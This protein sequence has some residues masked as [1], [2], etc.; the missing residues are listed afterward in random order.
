MN[1]SA[2]MKNRWLRIAAIS[3][4]WAFLGLV[5]SLEVYFNQRAQMSEWSDFGEVAIPQ[6]GRAAMWGCL[7][8]F[9]LMLWARMP[10]SSGHWVGGVLFHILFSFIVMTTYYLGRIEAY[11]ILF[12]PIKGGFW[13][14][15][16]SSF[17]GH[18][19]V[20]IAYYWGGH[21]VRLRR[22]NSS[23][24]TRTR[25][26]ERSGSRSRLIEAELKALREQLKPHFLFNTLNTVS[27]L[28]RDGQSELAVTLLARLGS[29][30]TDV[31]WRG[32]TRTKL[33]CGLKWIFWNATLKYRR[34]GFPTG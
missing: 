24:G 7:A 31:P 21:R 3:A 23:A 10:L 15:A 19:L 5:L 27:V 29:S 30:P 34:R 18:N 26:S 22:G 20:D 4:G 11:A 33:P 16:A 28:I 1:L 8:P 12:E 14:Y 2:P 32:I 13:H 9:I 6:F 17:Y 25:R